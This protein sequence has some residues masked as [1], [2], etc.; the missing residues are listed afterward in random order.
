MSHDAIKSTPPQCKLEFWR[1][2]I[3]T[4]GTVNFSE[5]LSEDEAYIL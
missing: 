2:E 5:L 1:S 4:E 3:V